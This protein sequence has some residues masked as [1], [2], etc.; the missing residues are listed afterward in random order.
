[1]PSSGPAVRAGR[2][3]ANV[4]Y[5]YGGLLVSTAIG[6]GLTPVL[7]RHLGHQTFGVYVLISSMIGYTSL[8][9][10][11]IGVSVM[12]LVADHV[13]DEDRS[14]LAVLVSSGVALYMGLGAAV[15]LAGAALYPFLGS[16]FG[17]HGAQLHSFR[18]AYV[19]AA[20]SA[21]LTF[22]SAI[23]TGLNQGFHDFRATNTI[24]A[25]QSAASACGYLS[26]VEIG[27]GLVGIV[28]AGSLVNFIAYFAKVVYTKRAHGVGFSASLVRRK[29]LRRI[30]SFS[31]PL[32]VGNLA[33]TVIFDVDNVVVGAVLGAATVTSFAVTGGATS[34]MESLGD[35][36]NAVV[37]PTA[38]TLRSRNDQN[39]LQR[40]LLESVRISALVLGP[41]VV[42]AATWGR[43]LF[44]LWVGANF[45][46]SA[47][48]LSVM[49]L[50]VTVAMVQGAATQF[51]IAAGKQRWMLLVSVPEAIANLALSVLLARHMGIVGV[52]WGT[53]I[54]TFFT[55]FLVVIPYACR[56][57][58]ASV[59]AAYRRLALPFAVQSCAYLALKY[60]LG[61]R[62]F[63]S[64][65]TL[66]A[67]SLIVLIT[68]YALCLALEPRERATYIALARRRLARKVA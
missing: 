32:I 22:P 30:A 39:G 65:L 54:P 16:A 61:V 10:L 23:Y 18:T 68:C 46:P 51:V 34:A 50:G 8:L 2:V 15:L 31:W 45:E 14:E 44:K 36:M 53:T 57:T 52:A 35:A 28:S 11:G 12:K 21:A 19:I 25:L 13:D 40:L 63:S 3:V 43:Q 20:V 47:P 9:D 60:V 66:G 42:L 56:L 27:A 5:N 24:G 59:L 4:L 17:V 58:E 38:S 37:L 48:T 1:M 55:T 33:V 64:L 26:A 29:A 7:I 67:A 49:A 62:S 6:F 41:F